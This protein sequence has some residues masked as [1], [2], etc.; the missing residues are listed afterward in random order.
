MLSKITALSALLVLVP[1]SF[2][3]A[4]GLTELKF[5]P[6]TIQRSCFIGY[7]TA[8]N[9]IAVFISSNDGDPLAGK[10]DQVVGVNLAKHVGSVVMLDATAKAGTLIDAKLMSVSDPLLT[11]LYV[12]SFLTSTAPTPE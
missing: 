5:C 9:K 1:A 12:S 8:P 10:E 11:A 4:Q 6:P 7:V 2:S 3:F